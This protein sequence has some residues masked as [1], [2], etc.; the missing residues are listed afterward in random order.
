MLILLPLILAFDI[1]TQQ[2]AWTMIFCALAGVVYAY[3]LYNKAKSLVD[4]SK[5]THY[6]LA[7]LR[8][9]LV[10]L[11]ALFLLN[12]LIK[13]VS[14]TS[15]KPIIVVAVDNSE[16]VLYNKD[17]AFYKNDF[18]QN[19]HQL[20]SDLSDKYEIRTLSFGDKINNDPVFDFKEKQT[21]ISSLMD[22]AENQFSGRNVGAI[23]IATDG[24]YNKGASPLYSEMSIKAPI[25]TIAMGDTT[26]KKDIGITRID[27]NHYAYLG[28][29]FPIE[30]SISAKQLKG[31]STTLTLNHKSETEAT[32]TIDFTNNNYNTTIHLQ[33]DAEENGIQRYHLKLSSLSEESNIQNNEQ[34][35]FI[36]VLDGRE[37]VLILASAPHPDIA[38]LK[39]T[40]E[41]NQNY[42]AETYLTDNFKDVVKKYNMV[43]LHNI[44]TT[45][46]VLTDIQ[47][48]KLPVWFIGSVP[49]DFTSGVK[50]QVLSNKT[51]DAEATINS[52]FPLFTIS[53][54]LKSFAKNFPA[55]KA[56]F[57][58]YKTNPAANILLSQKIG[59]VETDSP[60]M[61][62]NA[63]EETKSCYFIGDGLWKWRLRDYAEHENHNLFNELVNKT[64]QFLSAKID[65]SFFKVYF[66]NNFYENEPVEFES[67]VFNASYELIN[68]PE[69]SIA[70]TNSDNKKFPFTFSKTSNAYKLNAGFF[71]VGQYKF[72]AS[73]KDGDKVYNQK[74]EFTITA[75]K[76]ESVNTTADHQLL[77]NL[78]KK[79]GGEMVLP[80]EL[81][82]LKDMLEKRDDIK[83]VS[84]SEKRLTDIINIKWLFFLL[85]LLPTL[86]WF[87]R[88]RNGAY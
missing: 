38:A 62:F 71:P 54:E 59:A 83:T 19:I 41:N 4:V 39:E 46:K 75:I 73:V 50:I 68:E 17:S 51:N 23:L 31:K 8:F 64:I 65:K 55:V 78:A 18:Q 74:G 9:A 15:Q 66:K 80:T 34:D 32:Q 63:S 79:H 58:T 56:P 3:I 52:S 13:T 44:S 87:I 12:P 25:Y 43:I 42:E 16:S 6:V 5:S 49:P 81:N 21:D 76:V 2:P 36:Q 26:V 22:E 40:I 45:S 29:K 24:I 28:N 11:V 67:E 70:I 20:T 88:K 57:G 7:A 14:K 84:Y 48:A 69:V 60:L 53:D 27:H 61:A 85:L 86:E 82:K 30:I 37:K 77:Y 72:E 33:L 35:I 1:I 10:T 47:N